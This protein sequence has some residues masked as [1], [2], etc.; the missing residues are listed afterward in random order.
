MLLNSISKTPGLE[1]EMAHVPTAANQLDVYSRV[2]GGVIVS[3][4]EQGELDVHSSLPEL[5]RIA[6]MSQVGMLSRGCEEQS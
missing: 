5:T 6:C 2:L 3:M 1:Q 4:V